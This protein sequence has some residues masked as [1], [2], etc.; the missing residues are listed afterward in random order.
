ML[1]FPIL[2]TAEATNS[3]HLP[4]IIHAFILLDTNRSLEIAASKRNLI[5]VTSFFAYLVSS[6]LKAM[7]W[8]ERNCGLNYVMVGLAF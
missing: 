1:N 8:H 4:V 6:G 7:C 5:S 2:T 3:R